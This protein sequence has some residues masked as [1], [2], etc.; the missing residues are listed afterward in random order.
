MTTGNDAVTLDP[1]EPFDAVLIEMVR[2]NRAKRADYA[3]DAEG[4]H[5]H[6]N[7]YDSAYQMNF[8]PGHSVEYNISQ[9][10]ARLR[11]LLQKHFGKK[12]KPRNEP[13]RD[14]LKDRAVYAV[15]AVAVWD[16][17]SYES[18]WADN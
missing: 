18:D 11:V 10:Q 15:L 16:E 5:P 6:Q 4:D 1:T 8:T 14:T 12:G 7:F 13:I 9:K 2:L 17:G 3:G